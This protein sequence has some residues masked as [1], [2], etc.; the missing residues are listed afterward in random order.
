MA[1]NRQK[2]VFGSGGVFC[3]P[4]SQLC[5]VQSGTKLVL[6]LLQ[7]L[8]ELTPLGYIA[9]YSTHARWPVEIV[10]K[11]STGSCDP[12][13]RTVWMKYSVLNVVGYVIPDGFFDRIHRAV[14]ILRMEH[15]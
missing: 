3:F 5:R 11:R 2:L 9:R 6:V 15:S 7:G 12:T 8:I 13:H 1:K 10:S 14:T 4:P